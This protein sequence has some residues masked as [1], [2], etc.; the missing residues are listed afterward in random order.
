MNP[1][2]F[3]TKIDDVPCFVE[4]T[5]YSA[6]EPTTQWDDGLDEEFDYIII[7]KDGD[8]MLDLEQKVT[9]VVRERL[10]EEYHLHRVAFK[11]YI[12]D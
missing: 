8:R 3:D 10:L 12:E 7:N 5:H 2:R 4:V 6:G 1:K 11:H 9:A